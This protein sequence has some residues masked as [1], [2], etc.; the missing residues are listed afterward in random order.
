MRDDFVK[1]SAYLAGNF[2]DFSALT[3]A[4][5]MSKLKDPDAFRVFFDTLKSELIVHHED[6]DQALPV[7]SEP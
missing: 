3:F 5:I 2:G 4:I 6:F 7:R 1:W